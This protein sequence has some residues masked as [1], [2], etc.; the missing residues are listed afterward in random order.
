MIQRFYVARRRTSFLHF[1][2]ALLL[3]V[4]LAVLPAAAASIT[5]GDFEAVQIGSPFFSA[6]PADIPGWTHTGAAGDALLW[7]VGYSDS[8][9][10]V[11]VAGSGNQFVTMGGGF[12]SPGTAS[13][14]TS[15]TGLI[16]GNSYLLDF[17]MADENTFSS[18]QQITVDFT[19]GSPT[20]PVTFTAPGSS[21]ANYWRDWQNKEETF[22]ATGTSAIVRFT[23]TTR[24]DVGLDDVR[25]SDA[26]VPEPSLLGLL[27]CGLLMMPACGRMR[28]TTPSGRGSVSE[29]RWLAAF[30][31]R[32]KAPGPSA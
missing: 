15:I 32:G 23:A 22:L 6:N 29:F 12:E 18:D 16:A 5:N 31:R 7:S 26:I 2:P 17:M 27:I 3:A 11:T 21:S 30:A 24:F 4:I 14:S 1:A 25:V 28:G 20:L 19:S 9:G 8:G 10:S 13:W